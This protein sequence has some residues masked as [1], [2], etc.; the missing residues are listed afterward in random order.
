MVLPGGGK[1]YVGTGIGGAETGGGQDSPDRACAYVVSEAGEFTLEA[2]VA[3]GG[4][5]VCQAQDQLTDLL[6]DRRAA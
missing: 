6:G 1:L 4:V 3:P 5:F 2:A